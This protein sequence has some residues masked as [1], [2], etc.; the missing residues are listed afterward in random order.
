[1]SVRSFSEIAWSYALSTPMNPTNVTKKMRV[2]DKGSIYESIIEKIDQLFNT[3]LKTTTNATY[4]PPFMEG[5]AR[6]VTFCAIQIL[7]APIG[8]VYNGLAASYYKS[9]TPQIKPL[10]SI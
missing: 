2:D 5:T 7:V 4:L 6:V 1:M 10:S 9:K 8:I 3:P